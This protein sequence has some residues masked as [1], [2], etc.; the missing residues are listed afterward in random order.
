MHLTLC[1]RQAFAAVQASIVSV[2]ALMHAYAWAHVVTCTWNRRIHP[3]ETAS[4]NRHSVL[5]WCSP[6]SQ[7]NPKSP[8]FLCLLCTLQV[9]LQGMPLA[10]RFALVPLGPPL[11]SYNSTSKVRGA[12]EPYGSCIR[13]CSVL[14]QLCQSSR[15]VHDSASK[16]PGADGR[17]AMLGDT[18]ATLTSTSKARR[19]AQLVRVLWSS[20]Y[21][22]PV[23]STRP[24]PRRPC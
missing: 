23:T 5:S 4:H 1:C 3:G 21:L 7:T 20:R 19:L 15:R 14:H 18:D 16:A 11:L 13:A 17:G 22:W 8:H 6:A 9:H 10:R 2:L 24:Y 12:G